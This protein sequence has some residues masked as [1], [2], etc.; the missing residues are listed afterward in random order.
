MSSL[1]VLTLVRSLGRCLLAIFDLSIAISLLVIDCHSTREMRG[2]LLVINSSLEFT[3]G[4]GD[5]GFF[6]LFVWP[7]R[8]ILLV[9]GGYYGVHGLRIGVGL[10]CRALG[11][12]DS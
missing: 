6:L 3:I 2:I 5:D 12:T 7:C 10:R 4:C 11:R 9:M 8:L 1:G